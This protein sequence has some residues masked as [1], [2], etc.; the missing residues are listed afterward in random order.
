MLT[1]DADFEIRIC[2]A[3]FLYAHLHELTYTFL[4][5]NFKR[6]GLDDTVLFIEFQEFEIGRAS[7]MERMCL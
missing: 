5:K 3:S 2:F 1:T 7:S 4:I 6:I